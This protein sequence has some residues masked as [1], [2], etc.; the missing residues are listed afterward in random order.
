MK[1]KAVRDYERD[2]RR[3][4]EMY[5]K[6]KQL[7]PYHKFE[8]M[9]FMYWLVF[10][11]RIKSLP[12]DWIRFVTDMERQFELHG[13]PFALKL[14]LGKWFNY[15]VH[16]DKKFF[17]CQGMKIWYH[18]WHEEDNFELHLYYRAKYPGNIWFTINEDGTATIISIHIQEEYR[19][20]GLGTMAF[21]EAISQIRAKVSSLK[22][23]L[24]RQD[25]PEPDASFRWLRRQG[26]EINEKENGDYEI[27]LRIN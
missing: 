25:Y 24:E 21:R 23:T 26:F 1:S 16:S 14:K 13:M 27:E 3:L 11:S 10:K 6:Y 8:F 9:V 22:G 15:P 2:Q 18:C 20:K 5:E 12:L 17:I 7:S 19:N 4:R